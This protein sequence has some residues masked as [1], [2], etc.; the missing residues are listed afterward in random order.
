[1]ASYAVDTGRLRILA[2][3]LGGLQQELDSVALRLTGFQLGT[4]LQMRGSAVL[5]TRI[6]DC[7]WAAISQS[8]DLGRMSRGLTEALELYERMEANL[9]QPQTQAQAQARAGQEEPDFW[10]QFL[11][12]FPLLE[13]IGFGIEAAGRGAFHLGDVFSQAVGF[14]MSGIE[15][16]ID[17]FEEFSDELLSSQF[18]FELLGEAVVDGAV[19]F[20]VGTAVDAAI[21]AIFGSTAV[22]GGALGIAAIGIGFCWV[23][24]CICKWATGDDFSEL[25]VDLTWDAAH[26]LGNTVEDVT[27]A[28]AGFISNAPTFIQDAAEALWN[29]AGGFIDTLLPW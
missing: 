10:A 28:V 19:V 23:G 17:N 26:W 1:M 18:W 14:A 5:M 15:S 22:V 20:G 21:V 9:T 11:E 7:K 12:W 13:V 24:D 27:E 3:Q 16:M 29:G 2:E 4:T 6:G 25:I 8:D